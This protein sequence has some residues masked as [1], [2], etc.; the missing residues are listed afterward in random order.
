[1]AKTNQNIGVDENAYFAGDS[2][3]IIVNV[4]DR[5]SDLDIVGA[6]IEWAVA[7]SPGSS[8]II[9]ESDSGVTATVTDADAGE[10]TITVDEGVTDGLDGRYYH[11]VRLTDS[12]GREA[13][14][15][16]GI[17][18]IGTRVNT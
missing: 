2:L 13:V 17:L 5:G 12:S 1:M 6:S 15:T 8:E 14:V 11:E 4:D 7:E 18:R 10:L 3:E 9:S 16:R